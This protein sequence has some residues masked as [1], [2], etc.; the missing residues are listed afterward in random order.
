MARASNLPQAGNGA[1]RLPHLD[2]GELLADSPAEHRPNARDVQIDRRPHPSGSNHCRADLF[3]RDR[4]EITNAGPAV[5]LQERPQR[6]PDIVCFTGGLA[7]LPVIAVGVSDVQDR[8]VIER[9]PTTGGVLSGK[10]FPDQVFVGLSRSGRAVAP[11]VV[12]R[13]SIRT[14]ACPVDLWSVY[15]GVASCFD[16]AA[17]PFRW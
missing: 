7:I 5:E 16:I 11:E 12:A 1:Q 2:G 9:E 14:R 10:P 13:P 4:S 6:A 17:F 3:Q 15:A 8:Q